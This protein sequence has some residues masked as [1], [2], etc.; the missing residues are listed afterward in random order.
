MEIVFLQKMMVGV[1]TASVPCPL[2][3]AMSMPSVVQKEIFHWILCLLPSQRA[4][5]SIPGDRD[6]PHLQVQ[7]EPAGANDIP[8]YDTQPFRRVQV[9]LQLPGQG[10]SAPATP[11]NARHTIQDGGP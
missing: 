2:S 10:P 7:C 5:K 6:S 4:T 3:L 8:V 1:S 11:P 9:L